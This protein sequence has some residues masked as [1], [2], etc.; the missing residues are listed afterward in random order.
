MIPQI[1]HGGGFFSIFSMVILWVFPKILVPLKM[2]GENNGTTPIKMD[3]LGGENPPI[4]G[5]ILIYLG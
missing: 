2:D 1:K 4:F 5:N 3:D